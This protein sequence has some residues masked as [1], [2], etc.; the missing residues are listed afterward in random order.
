MMPTTRRGRYLFYRKR[1]RL[2]R[3]R[4]KTKRRKPGPKCKRPGGRERDLSMCRYQ[5]PSKIRFTAYY[6]LIDNMDVEYVYVRSGGRKRPPH[7]YVTGSAYWVAE[8]LKFHPESLGV[9]QRRVKVI[10]HLRKLPF[11]WE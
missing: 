11:R 10:P 7:F 2:R 9:I 3:E 6:P 1:S 8:I 4:H 5:Y